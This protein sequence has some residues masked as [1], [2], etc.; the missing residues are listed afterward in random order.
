MRFTRAV[1]R[2]PGSS[3]VRG[4]TTAGMGAPDYKQA[5][6]QHELYI[7]A[8]RACGL[9]VRVLPPL[10]EFPDSCFVE[11]VAL[12]TARGVIFTRP[13]APSRSGEVSRIEGAIRHLFDKAVPIESPGTLDAGDVMMVGDTFYIGRSDRTNQSGAEQ[14]IRLLAD[15]G[16]AGKIVPVPSGLHLKTSLSY[17]ESNRLVIASEFLGLEAFAGFEPIVVQPEEAYV[18]NCIWVNDRV[19]LPAGFPHTQAA[20][21][22]LGYQTVP[23]DLSEFRKL[24]GGASCLSLRF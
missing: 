11:D 10:E 21:E 17:L 22:S 15:F 2:I 8:L 24:D 7:D 18:A 6:V 14:L 13:G 16:Y 12:C 1:V 20:M 23:V 3:M 19:I 5:L 4:L 9:E